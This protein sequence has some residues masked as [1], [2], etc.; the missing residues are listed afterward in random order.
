[1]NRLN[2][3]LHYRRHYASILRLGLPIMLGQLGVIVTG[4]ADTV[5]VGH[6]STEALAS[7]SFV[8]NVFTLV[9]VACMGFSYGITPI[10]GALYARGETQSIGLTMRNALVLNLLFGAAALLAMVGFY[11]LIDDMGQPVE[12]LPL[13]RPYYVVILL[14]NVPLVLAGALKQFTDGVTH[15]RLGM[16]IL[17]IGN[18][19]NIVLNYLLIYGHCGLPEMGLIGAGVSTLI[20][21]VAMAVGFM[22][23]ILGSDRYRPWVKAFFASR[24][25][26][27]AMRTIFATSIPIAVQ[28]ALETGSFTA[29]SVMIGWLGKIP[30]AAYQIMV[31]FGM[32]GFMVYYG[33]G[34]SITIKISHYHGVGDM[35]KV[36]ECAAAGYHI[37]LFFV[38]VACSVFYFFGTPIIKLFTTDAEVIAVAASLIVP[39]IMYQFGD[40]TQVAFSNALRGLA[41]VR[42]AM[43]IAL[44]AYVIVGLPVCYL[45]GFPCGLGIVG[46]YISF[47]VSLLTAGLLFMHRF[48]SHFGHKQ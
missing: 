17:I 32:L 34:A 6:Y 14:S 19:L 29:A 22:A 10:I 47:T 37:I 8:N 11:E 30:L 45:L 5:M 26:L 31:I 39:M 43:L 20:A 36:R 44:T 35:H 41:D 25:S 9:M 1:M 46:V 24:V 3:K 42:P 4:F 27:E 18:L 33:I 28:M 16:W 2:N 48:Y 23:V 12:L 38:V 13:I 15:T 40:A 7:A 21:R